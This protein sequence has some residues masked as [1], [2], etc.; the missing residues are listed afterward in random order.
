VAE[1]VHAIYI[2]RVE[3]VGFRVASLCAIVR[4]V[5][6]WQICRETFSDCLEISRRGP[7][8]KPAKFVDNSAEM[9]RC[10]VGIRLVPRSSVSRVG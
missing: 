3:V 10:D 6:G 4:I 5:V 7:R 2:I 8:Q 9:S 1:G